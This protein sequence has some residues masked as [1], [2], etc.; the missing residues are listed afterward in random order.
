[1]FKKIAFAVVAMLFVVGL[2]A[3]DRKDQ[4][5]RR[6]MNPE[7]KAAKHVGRLDQRLNLSPETE[8]SL[9]TIFT[10]FYREK[11]QMRA[12][13]AGTEKK[14]AKDKA[15]F[16]AM[17]EKLD[18]QVRQVLTADQYAEYQKMKAEHKG[19]GHHGK[20]DGKKERKAKS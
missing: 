9:T 3:Q 8:K 14:P 4:K 19:R 5:D 6:V 11:Q 10:D 7:T 20:K 18:N 17:R 16:S 15:A 13:Q 12:A 2:Q 1:M